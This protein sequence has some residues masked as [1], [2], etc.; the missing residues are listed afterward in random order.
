MKTLKYISVI[1]VL[2]TVMSCRTL[3][4][5]NIS[6]NQVPVGDAQPY[7]LMDELIC[8]GALN[9]QQR[10]YDTIAELMQYTCVTSSS[11]EVCH[12]YYFAPSYVN[13]MWN[14]FAKWAAN[15]DHMIVLARDKKQPN[16]EAIGLTLRALWMDMLSCTFGRVPFSEAF[17]LRELD[18][19]KPKFDSEADIYAQLITDLEYANT[20]YNT[21]ITLPNV[22]KDKLYQ[23]DV[24]KWRKFTNSLCMRLLMRLSNRSTEMEVIWGE[25]VAAKLKKIL[26]N[27]GEYPIF[28]SIYDNA[29]VYFS[30]ESPF[31]NNWG[32]YVESTLSGH[33]GAENF[34]DLLNGKVDPRK[35]IWFQP[36]SSSIQWMGVRSGM[37]GDETQ[38]AGYPVMDFEMF[39]SYKL[40][41][42]FMNYD[43]V[44][45]I[46]AEARYRT[47]NDDWKAISGNESQVRSAYNRAI[48]ASCDF[49][50]YIYNQYLG[51]KGR[52]N[53]N[54]SY[55]YRNFAAV[56]DTT[57]TF[58]DG[59]LKGTDMTYYAVI[60]DAAVQEFIN[61]S[62]PFDMKTGLECI[63]NQKYVANFRV[64]LE[65]WND[66]RRTGF[67][68]LTIGTGTLNNGV[69]PRRLIYPTTTKTTNPDNYQLM[70]NELAATY[71]DGKDDMLTPVWWSE[72]GLSMEI[73]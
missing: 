49:W 4:E 25:S 31:Q 46:E 27:P 48:E 38:A 71:Y 33:R 44:L 12:R 23:G 57:I 8:N 63:L 30:G 52:F 66:Y 72:A 60:S 56:E 20:I 55:N 70:L 42:S 3:E 65:S 68:R 36:W 28:D 34:I 45:F 6:P 39:L 41:V 37:P 35:W 47:D 1:M 24:S 51:L 67:P 32:G 62:V 50:R 40:P 26:D 14:N 21:G 11:N 9:V 10:F 5:Y 2:L 69:L 16:Y 58:T 54:S 59:T 53:T 61:N 29:C 7:D 18:Q 13:N 43:E 73:R 17:K 64:G 15:A 22:V 19:N